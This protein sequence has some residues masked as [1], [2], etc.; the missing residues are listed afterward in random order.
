MSSGE[1]GDMDLVRDTLGSH[2]HGE[3]LHSVM[4]YFLRMSV[5]WRDWSSVAV[6]DLRFR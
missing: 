3:G 5:M 1:D 4:P 2:G 6:R